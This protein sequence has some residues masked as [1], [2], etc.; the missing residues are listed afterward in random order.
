MFNANFYDFQTSA[1]VGQQIGQQFCIDNCCQ[2][3]E[4]CCCTVVGDDKYFGYS[5]LFIAFPTAIWWWSLYRFE[6]EAMES[7]LSH[8]TWLP[9]CVGVF[10]L[11]ELR[12]CVFFSPQILSLPLLSRSSNAFKYLDSGFSRTFDI[13]CPPLLQRALCLLS[14]L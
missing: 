14:S 13:A 11:F 1:T 7:L 6:F 12:L 9:T 4:F 10:D 3:V 5:H 2:I 8:E